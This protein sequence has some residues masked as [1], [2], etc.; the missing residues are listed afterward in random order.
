MTE[1]LVANVTLERM[2]N[3]VG[4]NMVWKAVKSGE[5]YNKKKEQLTPKVMF[6][7]DT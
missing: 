2:K 7:R 4:D 5:R 3:E 1:A 6:F